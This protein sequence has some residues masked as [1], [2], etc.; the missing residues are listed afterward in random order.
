MTGQDLSVATIIVNFRA[1]NLVA[2]NLPPLIDAMQGR[3][4]GQI[5]IVDNCSENGDAERLQAF[6][7]NR[8]HDDLITVIAHPYNDGFG[9]GNNVGLRHLG[10]L[11][12]R[13][14]PPDLVFFLN[15][16]ARIKPG[17][18]DVLCSFMRAHPEA[19]FAG[20]AISDTGE[21]P[22]TA[23]F[24]FP[25]V[26][27][28]FEAAAK[29]GPVSKLLTR[30]I[31]PMPP[32]PIEAPPRQVDWVSGAAFMARWQ[33]LHETGW[34]DER[35]F[36]YFEETDLMRRGRNKGWQTWS[37][38][39][40]QVVHDEGTTTGTDANADKLFNSPHWRASKEL[41]WS[42]HFPWWERQV[43]DMARWTGLAL[44]RARQMP[45][46]KRFRIVR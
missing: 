11:A 33:A 32:V 10:H 3:P 38:P 8:A 27:G 44:N 36:L 7:A 28:E 40:A 20:A 23:S 25:S 19:G 9:A 16:D 45:Q 15:P 37:V 24:R 18:L 4:G 12:S 30:F 14:T 41:F 17:C 5:V 6:A 26:L 34:F 21:K 39:A 42:T 2:N 31:V 35:F 29:T 1:G 43:G 46:G 22:Q 13:K